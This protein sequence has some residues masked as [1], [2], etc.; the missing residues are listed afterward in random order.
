MATRLS[1][2][3]PVT[4]EWLNGLVEEINALKNN[5]SSNNTGSAA[6]SKIIEFIGPGLQGSS[7]IQVL[8][9]VINGLSTAK[10]DVFEADVNFSVPFA[11]KNVFIVCT[12]TFPSVGKRKGKP[13]KAAASVCAITESSF[14]LTVMLVDDDDQFTGSKQVSINYIAIGKKK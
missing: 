13:S 6:A 5:Q 3:I 7:S 12:P 8:T 9:G 4:T 1:D 2:G 11:D 14:K 10:A